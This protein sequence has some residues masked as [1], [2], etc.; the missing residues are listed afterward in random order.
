MDSFEKIVAT[1]LELRGYWVR[2]SFKVKLTKEDKRE[3][4]K[5]S[6]P[7]W[8]LDVVA[9]NAVKNEVLVVECKSYLDS[10]GVSSNDI[11]PSEKPRK[12]DRYKL[13]NDD[14]LRQV[15]FRRLAGQLLDQGLCS[16]NPAVHLCL[17][18][19]N[20]RSSACRKAIADHF[21]SRGWQ[22]FDDHW[23]K[24]S[25]MEFATEGYENDIAIVTAKILTR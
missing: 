11:G 20:V 19:G 6:S 7:R 9:Y 12:S 24:K 25:L 16:P 2:C 3:I 14:I 8:E 21:L 4:G 1:I 17:A 18:A 23:I 5:P 13:F 10:P 15:V 22:F